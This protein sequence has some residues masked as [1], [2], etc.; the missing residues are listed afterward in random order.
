[1]NYEIHLINL[2]RI[3]K[4]LENFPERATVLPRHRPCIFCRLTAD[5]RSNHA[6]PVGRSDAFFQ[7]FPILIQ[8]DSFSHQIDFQQNETL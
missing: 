8:I 4:N 2:E 6:S 7:F 1:M 3:I 5:A